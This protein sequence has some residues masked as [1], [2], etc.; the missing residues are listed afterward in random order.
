MEERIQENKGHD[1]KNCHTHILKGTNPPTLEMVQ[2]HTLYCS[3]ILTNIYLL[4]PLVWKSLL[5]S[6][7]QRER[8]GSL[9]TCVSC[10]LESLDFNSLVKA[11]TWK[12]I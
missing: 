7:T 6:I 2:T 1:H 4:D 12:L 11:L 10:T 3:D 5:G 9:C 8:Q